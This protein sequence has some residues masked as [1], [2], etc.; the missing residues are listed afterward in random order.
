MKG[1]VDALGRALVSLSIR[2]E[3]VEQAYEVDAW[4]DT[5]FDGELVMPRRLIEDAA[6]PQSAAIEA[7]LADGASVTL[8]TY[9][10][11][12]DWFDAAVAVEVIAN[13]GEFP[14]L[15]TGLLKGRRLVIDYRTGGVEIT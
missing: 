5:A 3:R 8:E 10:C 6:L 13:E 7:R 2:V 1:T 9:S 14:L 15:G 12:L 11:V 4:V